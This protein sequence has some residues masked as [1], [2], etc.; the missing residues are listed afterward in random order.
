MKMKHPAQNNLAL[1][2]KAEHAEDNS[3][4]CAQHANAAVIIR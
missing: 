1:A 2:F 4:L 3:C